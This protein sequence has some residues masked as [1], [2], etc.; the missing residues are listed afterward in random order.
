MDDYFAMYAAGDLMGL[1]QTDPEDW[2]AG[3]AEGEISA[4]AI[5]ALIDERAAAKAAKDF[6][7]ADEIRDDLVARGVRLE[8]GPSGTTWRRD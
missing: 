4:D 3:D 8:D 5:Q 2:F 1:L 6:A 7:R